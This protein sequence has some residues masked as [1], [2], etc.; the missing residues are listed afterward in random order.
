MAYRRLGSEMM[1][2]ST[3]AE[4]KSSSGKCVRRSSKRQFSCDVAL[5]T[6]GG[7]FFA[8]VKPLERDRSSPVNVLYQLPTGIK[9]FGMIELRRQVECVILHASDLEV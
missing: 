5:R 2:T 6:E 4:T 8:C 1:E 9:H 3:C 7:G